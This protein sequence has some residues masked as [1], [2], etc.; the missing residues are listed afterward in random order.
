MAGANTFLRE[1]CQTLCK[2]AYLW[3]NIVTIM[4]KKIL[5]T[6]FIAVAAVSAAS[7]QPRALGI[8]V[9][10]SGLEADYQHSFSKNQFLEGNF[11][12]DFG[13]DA[14]GAPGVKATALYNFV[15]ARPAWTDK[16]KWALYAGPGATLG[17]VNDEVH[18]KAA[19]G[20][21]IVRYLDN[22]FMLGIC[23]Q[24]GLEY[25]FWFP[26]QL[27][28]D[29]RPVIGMHINSGYTAHDGTHY[30]TR[31]GFYDNGLL[32]FAPTISVRYR[33]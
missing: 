3:E 12:L 4:R 25:T 24:V 15:W 19:D 18:F 10:V 1:K 9:G 21:N 2:S 6:I 22:G 7:A 11:G 13:Y 5:T 8:R 16:G 23:G 28:V 29:L 27:S 32:G 31:V 26:L 33:F 20:V 17:Y 30:G 14:N